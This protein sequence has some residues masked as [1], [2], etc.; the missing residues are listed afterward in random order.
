MSISVLDH[1]S[2]TLVETW[3]SDERIIE[4]ARMSTNK[5]FQGWEKDAKLLKYLYENQHMTPFEMAGATFEIQCPMMVVWEWVR[6]RTQSYNIMSARYTE[7]P[8]LFYV[9]AP[10][11]IQ[12]QAAHNKQSS[13]GVLSDAAQKLAISYINASS[14]FAFKMYHAMLQ[15]G[16]AREIARLILPFNAYTRMRASC[17]LRNWMAFLKLREDPSAQYEIRVF[18]EAVHLYLK[19]SFPH[20]MEL[21]ENVPN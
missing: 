17:D 1:G 8:E 14:K 13:S 19:Y 11:R 16:V 20:T 12:G 3:G 21:F 15:L 9:P 5:G 10:D 7:I 2:V 18:A 4:A 6:H